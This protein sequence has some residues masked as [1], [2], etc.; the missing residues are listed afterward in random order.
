MRSLIWCVMNTKQA[1]YHL[2][3]SLALLFNLE[4]VLLREE[5]LFFRSVYYEVSPSTV[6]PAGEGTL[7]SK[8]LPPWVGLTSAC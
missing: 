7:L 5:K 6:F 1:F 8:A 4:A 3:T 2:A